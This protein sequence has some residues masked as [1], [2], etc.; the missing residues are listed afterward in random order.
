MQLIKTERIIVST[1]PRFKI[2]TSVIK[3]ITRS[4]AQTVRLNAVSI[5]R[6]KGEEVL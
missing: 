2:G 1:S 4:E 6:P 5:I 3:A